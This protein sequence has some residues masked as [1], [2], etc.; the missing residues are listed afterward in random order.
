M[1]YRE[2]K[3]MREIH[4]IREKHYEATKDML[5]EERVAFTHK[6]VE[7]LLEE[8]KLTHLKII[9]SE[10]LKKGSD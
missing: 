2:P 4:K 5:P 1:R 10:S 8:W 9:S 6:V 3:S 7:R